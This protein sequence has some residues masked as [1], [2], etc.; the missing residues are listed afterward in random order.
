MTAPAARDRPAVPAALGPCVDAALVPVPS[1]LL[2][3][4]LGWLVP[5]AAHAVELVGIVVAGRLAE[6][7]GALLYALLAVLVL[8]HY[9]V[10]YRVKAGLAPGRPLIRAGLGCDGRLL[11]VTVAA[12]AGVAVPVVA[13]LTAWSGAL[14]ASESVRA[15]VVHARAGRPAVDLD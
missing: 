8:H 11:A 2:R 6:V 14:F 7:P 13:A 5:P 12:A 9:D 1:R 15:W 10:Y 3:S 4:P